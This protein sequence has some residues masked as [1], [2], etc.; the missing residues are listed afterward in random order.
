[1]SVALGAQVTEH[2]L[3]KPKGLHVDELGRLTDQDP[4]KLARVL[5]TLATNHVYTEGSC[6]L[7]LHSCAELTR[8]LVTPN[9][10]ANNRLSMKLLAT[11]P[12]SS[13][14]RIM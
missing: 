13:L 5:R 4:G 6:D 2:L 1:M 9:V 8:G 12:V 14:V 3:D 7:M 10:F 11:D